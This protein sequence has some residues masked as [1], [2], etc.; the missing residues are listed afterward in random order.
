MFPSLRAAIAAALVAVVSV[1]AAPQTTPAAGNGT[2]ACNNS[3]SLCSRQ[4]NRITYMGAHD[5]S[6]LRD[7]STGNSLSGNQFMNATVALDAGFRLLQA[8]VHK[9]NSTL[10]LCHTT[11]SLL[12]SGP[13]ESW[14]AAVNDWMS[15]NPNE[16]VTLVLVN[17]DNAPASDF[18]SVFEKSGISK[19]GY[20]STTTSATGNWP[21]LDT[22]ISQGTRVVSF[23][24]NMKYSSST[25]YLL[26]E[27]DFVF[28][29]PFEVTELTGFNC[30]LD[31]PSGA[32][33]ATTALFNNFMS[34]VNHFK[35]QSLG[36]GIMVPDVDR[37]D[38][39]N[40]PA[41]SADGNLGK[42][43]QACKTQWNQQPNFVLVD[44][45]D[46]ASPIEA[47]D[48]MNGLSSTTGRKSAPSSDQ[49]TGSV[50]NSRNLEH[51]AL[52][53]FLTATLLLV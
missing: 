17:S 2:K 28:E 33:P 13:L 19:L 49:S 29:T 9:P 20:Q 32:G 35:Y 41:T 52:V 51:G 3:P 10:E 24:T 22:M 36:S 48:S 43:L 31:R 47:A 27:F 38:V 23:V 16:V 14:L 44:F 37:I 12:D 53:A 5:S 42:H 7:K 30:T 8:Q 25:P 40:S 50:T 46:R 39:V 4:Y 34:L 18:G 45:W 21:T 11:C 15:K 26:P 6:F 1:Q